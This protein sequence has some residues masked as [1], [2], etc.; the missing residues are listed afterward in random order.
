VSSSICNSNFNVLPMSCTHP[1]SQYGGM[2][3]CSL[4]VQCSINVSWIHR[5]IYVIGW[6]SVFPDKAC[7]TVDAFC[8]TVQMASAL[9]S[10]LLYK[11]Q[12]SICIEG[13]CIFRIV[14]GGTLGDLDD[15]RLLILL[16]VQ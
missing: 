15:R 4:F 5:A 1:H 13:L 6:E 14:S 11:I 9:I 10:F 3:Y 8:S 2:V 7:V 12:T 16:E